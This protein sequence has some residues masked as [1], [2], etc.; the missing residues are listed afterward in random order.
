VRDYEG[1]IVSVT[2]QI[3]DDS[4]ET[5]ECTA[6][7]PFWVTAGE[8][9]A[10]RPV[11]QA[12]PLHERQMAIETHG[13]RWTEAKWLR[14]G[15]HFLTKSGRSATVS[16]LTI[17]IE[18]ARVY[19]LSVGGMHSYAVS[20]IGLL[21]HNKAAIDPRQIV[22]GRPWPADTPIDLIARHLRDNHGVSRSQFRERLHRIKQGAQMEAADD[23]IFGRT[24]DVYDSRTDELIGNL[25]AK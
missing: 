3:D 13:G 17:R 2:L 12:L 11:V 16:G 18:R 5:I 8:D 1:E 10:Q 9:L 21:V 24:G 7:H 15:D 19:N 22:P 4:T 6:E 23:V 20:R 14:L 25:C